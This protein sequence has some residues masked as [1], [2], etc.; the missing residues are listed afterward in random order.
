MF[1]KIVKFEDGTYGF[2]RWTFHGYEYKD[3]IS[4]NERFWFDRTSEF[5]KDC[6]GS[7]HT[8]VNYQKRHKTQQRFKKNKNADKGISM[9]KHEIDRT[10]LIDILKGE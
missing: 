5:Y 3:L 8:V 10:L 9:N 2:R 6:K 7:L 4:R 1:E